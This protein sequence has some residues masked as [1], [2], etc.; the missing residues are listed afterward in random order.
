[1]DWGAFYFPAPILPDSFRRQRPVVRAGKRRTMKKKSEVRSQK[2]EGRKQNSKLKI[3]NL[4]IRAQ[5]P[6][7]TLALS[8]LFAFA[9]GSGSARAA[10]I[11]GAVLDPG[12]L[13]VVGVRVTLL[14]SLAALAESET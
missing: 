13:P 1:M 7:G 5:G 2:A 6:K 11:K 12:G 14:S 3:Q 4:K 9:L 8:L 10:T